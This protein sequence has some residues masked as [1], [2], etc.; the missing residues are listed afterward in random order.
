[1]MSQHGEFCTVIVKDLFML[2]DDI[3][4]SCAWR[5]FLS[6]RCLAS[7]QLLFVAYAS[8]LVV[9]VACL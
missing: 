4:A 2:Q 6:C 8:E 1:M 9:Q 5:H 3:E 7:A